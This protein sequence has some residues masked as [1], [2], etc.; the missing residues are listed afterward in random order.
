MSFGALLNAEISKSQSLNSMVKTY[1]NLLLVFKLEYFALL[2]L[3][4]KIA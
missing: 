3:K 4:F 1:F 2:I